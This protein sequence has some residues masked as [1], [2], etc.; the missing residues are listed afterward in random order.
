MEVRG[1]GDKSGF[2]T[3][4]EVKNDISYNPNKRKKKEGLLISVKV[5]G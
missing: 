5:V 2:R 4:S 1:G 3:A